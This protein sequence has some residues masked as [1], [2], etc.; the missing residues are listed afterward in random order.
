MSEGQKQLGDATMAKGTFDERYS[1]WRSFLSL[2]G[3]LTMIV[4]LTSYIGLSDRVAVTRMDDPK[5][6]FVVAV[7]STEYF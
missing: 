6:V 1:I 4:Q 5:M 7:C 3:D 2:V